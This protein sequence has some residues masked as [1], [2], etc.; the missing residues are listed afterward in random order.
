MNLNVT[1]ISELVVFGVFLLIVQKRIWPLFIDILEKRQQEISSGLA[2]AQQSKESLAKA[3]TESEEIIE[4][5]KKKGI[6]LVEA[7]Q[8]RASAIEQGAKENADKILDQAKKSA[9]EQ[10]VKA[11]KQ[12][13]Q[14]AK[15]HYTSL[16]SKA[17]GKVYKRAEKST[18]AQDLVE[19]VK[20]ES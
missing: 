14:E 15:E 18:I 7:A 3:Q 19:S 20:A 5:S 6:Q 11:H 8:S 4:L 9:Q 16:V 13:H 12:F 2:A 10:L 1:L 17:L